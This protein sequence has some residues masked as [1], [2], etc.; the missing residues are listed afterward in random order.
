MFMHS[1]T[2][3][4]KTALRA[5]AILALPILLGACESGSALSA[6]E[7]LSR[8]VEYRDKGD[9]RAAVIEFKNVLQRD[10]KHAEARWLLG[11]T[12]LS[13][14]MGAAAGKELKRARG[15][16]RTGADIEVALIKT[17]LLQGHYDEALKG[18]ESVD[19]SN[20]EADLFVLEGE[21]QQGLRRLAPARTAFGNALKVSPAS[22]KARLGLARVAMLEKDG[23]KPPS[24]T[25]TKF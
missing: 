24:A 9:L 5:A 8:A 11:Q 4:G 6:E 19:R 1:I 21:A 20:S 25:S 2:I 10:G 14:G 17:S 12:Y 7:H 13:L 3:V 18:L 16:G 23:E 22:T 15:L